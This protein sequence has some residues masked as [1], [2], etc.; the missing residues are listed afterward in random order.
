MKFAR[1]R[2]RRGT[3]LLP[4]FIMALLAH[5]VAA[6]VADA[7]YSRLASRSPSCS[8]DPGVSRL[9]VEFAPVREEETKSEEPA[10]AEDE[11]A[12]APVVL[13]Q[14]NA[15]D[16]PEVE[17]PPLPAPDEIREEPPQEQEVVQTAAFSSASDSQTSVA[18]VSGQGERGD[19]RPEVSWVGLSEIKPRYP[20]GSR[21]RGEEGVVKVRVCVTPSGRSGSVEIVESSGFRALDRA[22]VD[23]V[24]KAR[25]KA[26]GGA[27]TE[28]GE[29]VLTFRFRLMD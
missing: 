8:F 6:V 11:P 17:E 19:S 25:F 2:D 27:S 9:E 13:P 14:E 1:M 5:A 16:V 28:G 12:P 23:A 21:V 29:I 15:V 18:P 20:F 26:E 7:V 4:A 22:A 10:R 3:D 24:R